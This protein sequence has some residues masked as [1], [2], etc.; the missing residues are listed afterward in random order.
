MNRRERIRQRGGQL[1]ALS[2]TNADQMEHTSGFIPVS[3]W[4]GA[5]FTGELPGEMALFEH[6]GGNGEGERAGDMLLPFAFEEILCRDVGA[7]HAPPSVHLWSHP[8]GIALGLRDSRL[9]CAEAG[10]KSLEAQGVRTAIRHSG[11]A[12]VPLDRGVVNVSLILPKSRSMLDFHRDFRLLSSLIYEAARVSHPDGAAK[13]MAG[14]VAGSYC[15]GEYDLSVGGRKFCGIAQRRQS[16]AYFVHA[17]VI[18][19]GSGEERG[20]LV[21]R[22]Y[23]EAACGQEGLDYPRVNPRTMAA[24]G[25]LGGPDTASLFAQGVKTAVRNRGTAIVSEPEL[26]AR[27]GYSLDYGQARV[28]EA[29]DML[30]RRYAR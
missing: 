5:E 24:L 6:L 7:G 3:D 30:R 26:A 25:E 22:F 15:P 8:G 4:A 2:G 10:M 9:P 12:A 29:A 19:A 13:I 20:G 16:H 17:F 14:E 1:G 18:V 23:E 21:R 11:G 28:T 27:T